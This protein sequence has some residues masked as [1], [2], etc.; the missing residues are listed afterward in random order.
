MVSNTIQGINVLVDLPSME[1]YRR[2]VNILHLPQPSLLLRVSSGESPGEIFLGP[3][4]VTFEV[5]GRREGCISA[6]ECSSIPR[7]STCIRA[8]DRCVLVPNPGR[9]HFLR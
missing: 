6:A 8:F 5:G 4:K 1:S 2:S 7:C 9:L 3:C